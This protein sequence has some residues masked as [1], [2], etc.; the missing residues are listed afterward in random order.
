MDAGQLVSDE[1]V[2][3]MVRERL[4]QADA[5]AASCSTDFRARC[6]RPRRSTGW[7]TARR[8]WLWTSKCRGRARG[9]AAGAADLPELRVERDAR[10][11]GLREM[12]RPAGAA[13][14]RRDEV[15]RERLRVYARN[16]RPI[17]EF[18][19]RRP[20][21]RCVDGDQTLDAVAADIAAAVESVV[22]SRT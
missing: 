13:V 3:G 12:R 2:I 21:F 11:A 15:V 6:R 10:R 19:E 5:G 22:G 17:V 18:Y 16:T 7:W 20:T 4:D 1:L 14:R 9:A 8:W